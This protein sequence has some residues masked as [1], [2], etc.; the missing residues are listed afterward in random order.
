MSAFSIVRWCGPFALFLVSSLFL[1]FGIYV[2]VRTYHLENPLEFVMAFFSS[3]LIILIS[4]VGMISPSVQVY[5][6]WR[7][8]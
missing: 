8:R 4:M 1:L 5:L 6:A 7:K 2:M 3:S